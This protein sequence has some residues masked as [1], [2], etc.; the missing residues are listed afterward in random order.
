MMNELINIESATCADLPKIE[1]L[2]RDLI[3][4]IYDSYKMDAETAM[5][6]C[7]Q[8]IDDLY[9]HILLARVEKD[10]VGFVNFTM[11][12]TVLH[13]APSG[14]IDELIVAK[15][16]RGKGIGKQL[17]E[18]AIKKCRELD[19]CEIEVSTE[20]TNKKA[21]AFYKKCGFDEDAVLL[22][23]DLD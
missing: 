15:V 8:M 17:I 11:R 18:A 4:A 9:S 21:R 22:E 12:R 19:C 14:L 3:E 10:V 20:K 6:N 5:E 23:C 16:Y 1:P 13:H 2:L 7:R